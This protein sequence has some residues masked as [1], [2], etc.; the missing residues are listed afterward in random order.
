MFYAVVM[1]SDSQAIF[2]YN[3]KREAME[4][5]HSELAYAYSQNI[6]TTCQ[7]IDIQGTNYATEAFEAEILPQAE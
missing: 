7:V 3:T 1:K 4:K 2:K 6:T 5:Y